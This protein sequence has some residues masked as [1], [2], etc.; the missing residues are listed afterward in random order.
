V[1]VCI[2]GRGIVLSGPSLV[3]VDSRTNEVRAVWNGAK[4]LLERE[5]GSVCAARPLRDGVIADFERTE[6]MLR[7][8]TGRV[9]RSG[10]AHPRVV[11]AGVPCGATGAEKRAM[12]EACLSAGAR[13]ARLIEERLAAAI[14]AGLPV[15]EAAGWLVVDIGGG[16]SEAAVISL[17]EIVV[18]Q[19]IR[20]GGDE[21]DEAVNQVP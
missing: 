3:V 12:V 11:V 14:G 8:F 19:S 10:R 2:R 15:A 16:T 7:R 5:T 9:S 17:G 4:R 6:V 20:V 1:V 18:S 21:L 13:H